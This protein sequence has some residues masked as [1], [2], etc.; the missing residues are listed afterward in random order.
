MSKGNKTK[1]VN[2]RGMAQFILYSKKGQTLNERDVYAVNSRAIDGLLQFE[3]AKKGS[4]F[5]L[6]YNLAGLVPLHDFMLNPLNRESF[7]RIL[8][9]VLDVLKN[10]QSNF[11]N[12][13]GLFLNFAY[14]YVNPATQK[15]A[16]IYSPIQNYDSGCELRNFLLEIIQVATFVQ[17]EDSNYV[18]EYIRILNEGIN[19]SVF[20]LEEYIKGLVSE[21]GYKLEKTI[22]CFKCGTKVSLGTNFCSVCGAKIAGNTG[23]IANRVIYDPFINSSRTNTKTEMRAGEYEIVTPLVSREETHTEQ[24]KTS[25]NF[26]S[27]RQERAADTQGLSDKYR[28]IPDD[29]GDTMLLGMYE[30]MYDDVRYLVRTKNREKIQIDKDVFR[31]G[32][33]INDCDYVIKDNNTISRKHA[34]IVKSQ[35][36]YFVVDLGSTNK[37]YVDGKNVEGQ[38]QIVSGSKIKLANEEF[39]FYV[40]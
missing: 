9:N 38:M 34:E 16:F 32:K 7:A 24:G 36:G 12:L 25:G 5:E 18:K 30:S 10:M 14:V 22:T 6:M 33:S 11:F 27:H 15:L 23:E 13:K 29:F 37:T 40:E 26:T 39:T 31:L 17:E 19:F 1:F 3:V 2:K 20:E 4:N 35:D 21:T 8:Q 28:A